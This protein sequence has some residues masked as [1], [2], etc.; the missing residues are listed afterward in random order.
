MGQE[1]INSM[2]RSFLNAQPPQLNLKR[3]EL[4]VLGN[5]TIILNIEDY[6]R[7]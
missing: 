3:Q 7:D 2:A 1:I 4:T 5:V 6:K